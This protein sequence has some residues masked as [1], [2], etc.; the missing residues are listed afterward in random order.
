MIFA[1]CG[2]YDFV[3]THPGYALS[4]EIFDEGV[5]TLV[6]LLPRYDLGFWSRY[7]LCEADFHPEIDPATIGYHYLHIVQLK[8]MFR[9]T[10]RE[11]FQEYARRWE[12]YINLSNILKMYKLKYSALR[13]MN[14][15]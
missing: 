10:G 9:L 4:R 11:K 3:R 7:S 15:L 12:S 6:R 14:R 1:L 5:E 2:V 8:L 13:K